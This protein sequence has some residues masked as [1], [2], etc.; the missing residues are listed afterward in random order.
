MSFF[1][2]QPDEVYKSH[3]GETITIVCLA[4]QA[5]TNERLVVY[6]IDSRAIYWVLPIS[7]FFNTIKYNGEIVPRF[8][9]LKS[10]SYEI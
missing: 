1:T 4:V 7:T 10:E 6:R 8:K 9:K 5:E 3:E 2:V